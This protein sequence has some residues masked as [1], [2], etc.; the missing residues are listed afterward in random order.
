[1]AEI[2][3]KSLCYPQFPIVAAPVSVIPPTYT[4]NIILPH[5]A[6]PN[7]SMQKCTISPRPI[8]PNLLYLILPIPPNLTY[9][10]LPIP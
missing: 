6:K 7:P 8:S 4:T 3:S 10:I 2:N 5:P 9:P 1:M